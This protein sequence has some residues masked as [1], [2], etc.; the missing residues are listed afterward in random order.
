MYAQNVFIENIFCTFLYKEQKKF[1]KSISIN[2]QINRAL[3]ANMNTYKLSFK[4]VH[5]SIHKILEQNSI[6]DRN[7]GVVSVIKV[8]ISNNG[9]AWGHFVSKSFQPKN[10][11]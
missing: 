6:I 11:F 9:L 10:R 2:V 8:K 7:T 3:E 1:L 5:C 4:Y